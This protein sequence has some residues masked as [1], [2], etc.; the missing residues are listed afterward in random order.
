MPEPKKGS[1]CAGMKPAWNKAI[2]WV[3][4]KASPGSGLALGF[5]P[6][7]ALRFR[8]FLLRHNTRMPRPHR[9]QYPGA[10]Y[11]VITRGDRRRPLFHDDGHYERF[12][13]GLSEQVS[14]HSWEVFAYCWMRGPRPRP[15]PNP[16]AEPRR[17]DAALV[18]RLRQ[19]VCQAEPPYRTPVPGPLQ[20]GEE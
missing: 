2:K 1:G 3:S 18:V 11:H 16:R 15:D 9:V 12:T 7:K 4:G 13:R 10:I 6:G 19:L 5:R 8:R 20:G 14:R 17:R